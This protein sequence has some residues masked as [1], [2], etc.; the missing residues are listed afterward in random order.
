MMQAAQAEHQVRSDR[1][2][3]DRNSNVDTAVE[4]RKRDRIVITVRIARTLKCALLGSANAREIAVLYIGQNIFRD[5]VSY[6]PAPHGS[7][8]IDAVAGSG[9]AADLK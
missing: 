9:K 7:E 4:V 5:R 1:L 3:V 6:V 2:L 8:L